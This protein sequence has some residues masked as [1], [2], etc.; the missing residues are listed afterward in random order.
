MADLGITCFT[1]SLF[2][3]SSNI[4]LASGLWGSLK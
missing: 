1:W 4:F 2:T 3:I